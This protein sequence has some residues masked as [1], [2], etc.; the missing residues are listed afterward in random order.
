MSEKLEK[1]RKDWLVSC[2]K[3][4]RIIAITDEKGARFREQE[5]LEICQVTRFYHL[6]PEQLAELLSLLKEHL[7]ETPWIDPALLGQP[8]GLPSEEALPETEVWITKEREEG[9]HEEANEN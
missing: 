7:P 5:E 8:D 6:N 9:F 1:L 3:R 2:E 4:D